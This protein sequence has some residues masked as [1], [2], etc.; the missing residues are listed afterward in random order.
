MSNQSVEITCTRCG[1]AW[2]ADLSSLDKRD[3]TVYKGKKRQ[4]ECRLSCPH[5]GTTNVVT[6]K[7]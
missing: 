5:C 3:Q 4:K 7:V 2:Q 1:R 6:V